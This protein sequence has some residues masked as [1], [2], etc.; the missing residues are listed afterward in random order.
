MLDHEPPA[1]A[2]IGIATGARSS[3]VVLD[4]E[5]HV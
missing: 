1:D 2:N 5:K 3:F 4:E